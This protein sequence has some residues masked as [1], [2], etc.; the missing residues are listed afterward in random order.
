[1]DGKTENAKGLLRL[2][3]KNA[4]DRLAVFLSDTNK[5]MI[6]NVLVG[7]LEHKDFTGPTDFTAVEFSEGLTPC[8][9]DRYVQGGEEDRRMSRVAWRLM[10]SHCSCNQ[11]LITHKA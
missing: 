11:S 8:E 6:S 2:S 1:M 3:L 5:W 7:L 4:G 10:T 9:D